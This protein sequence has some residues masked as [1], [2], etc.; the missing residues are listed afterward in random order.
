MNKKPRFNSLAFSF[1]M[2]VF[3][4]LCA[5]LTVLTLIVNLLHHAGVI[6][7][8]HQSLLIPL[9]SLAFISLIVG[10]AASFFISSLFLNPFRKLID[11]MNKMAQGDYSVRL[12]LNQNEELRQ[13]SDSFNRMAKELSSTE[14]LRSDFINSF[15][16]EFKT[17]LLSIKGFASLLKKKQLDDKQ[18]EEYLDIIIDETN[19]LTELSTNVL[20]LTKLENTEILTHYDDVQLDEQIR[21]CILFLQ[22][23]WETKQISF[24]LD[25]SEIIIKADASLLK[26]VWINLLDNAIKFSY[27]HSTIHV[28]LIKT[29][30]NISVMI[31]DEGIGMTQDQLK[32]IFK[33]FYQ[34]DQSHYEGGNGLGLSVV[35]RI[36]ELHHGSVHAESFPDQGSCFTVILPDNK[37]AF[38]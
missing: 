17:P 37:H 6:N 20:N 2:T 13:I 24:D 32:H 28:M 21:K 9:I 30:E 19:H 16:H 11:A 3:L 38:S 35:K 26:Q 1:I 23:K 14:I 22:P 8:N 27:D 5:T 33:K 15:S 36:V 34:A 29:Q 4:V 7:L 31:K 10:T 25:L 18:R 12:D